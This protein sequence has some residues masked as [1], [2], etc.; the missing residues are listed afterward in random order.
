MES[1]N[2]KLLDKDLRKNVNE[3]Y[4]N[5]DW[6]KIA[7]DNLGNL[8]NL[9]SSAFNYFSTKNMQK[10]QQN[11][12]GQNS[13]GDGTTQP[14]P[15]PQNYNYP[16]QNNKNSSNNDKVLGMQKPVGTTIAVVGGFVVLFG[17]FLLIKKVV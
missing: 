8:I 2:Y 10:G 14:T 4:S 7:T 6:G 17:A 15:P 3:E 11:S 9:G 1:Y 5:A 12:G 16:P 13:Q